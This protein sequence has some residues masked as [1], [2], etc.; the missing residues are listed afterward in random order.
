[1][2]NQGSDAHWNTKGGQKYI[3]KKTFSK[4]QKRCKA[5]ELPHAGIPEG[6]WPGGSGQLPPLSYF[7]LLHCTRIGGFFL[8]LSAKCVNATLGLVA[9]VVC[10]ESLLYTGAGGGLLPS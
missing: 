10:L 6:D 5:K 1:M 4:I 3:K 8:G 9:G 2:K 7:S